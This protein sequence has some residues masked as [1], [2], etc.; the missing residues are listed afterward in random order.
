VIDASGY[1]HRVRSADVYDSHDYEQDPQRFASHHAG[2]AG[3]DAFVNTWD[4]R[5]V[6]IPW[7][8]Q[9]YLVSEFGGAWWAAEDDD[10]S[11]GYGARPA[12]TEQ[13][14]E[15][16]SDL[17]GA[18][19]DNPAVAGYCYTQLTDVYQEKNGILDFDRRPKLPLERLAAV[20]RRRAAIEGDR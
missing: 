14:F 1:S 8:G 10:A 17:C 7:D 2:L 3:G 12:S 19:L 9:P 13:L 6:S 4:G 15:R 16:F 5:T 11:W 18:L 20:Q